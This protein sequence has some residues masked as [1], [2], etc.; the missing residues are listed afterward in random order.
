MHTKTIL[1]VDDDPIVGNVVRAILKGAHP[2]LTIKHATDGS[3]AWEVMKGSSG[4]K[5]DLV[6][7]DV[8]MPK[9][10]GIELA[11]K[12]RQDFP[13]IHVVLMSGHEEPKCHNAHGFIKKP[14]DRGEVLQK[15]RQLLERSREIRPTA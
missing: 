8:Y 13:D 15:V 9:M 11:Q 10:S 2:L 14:F 5:P 6:I 1:I 12:I 4:K 7:S 3:D